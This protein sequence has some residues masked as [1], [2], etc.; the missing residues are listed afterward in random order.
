MNEDTIKRE[1]NQMPTERHRLSYF[2]FNGQAEQMKLH[3]DQIQS[4][5]KDFTPKPKFFWLS[6]SIFLS[7]YLTKS[8]RF[9]QKQ[10]NGESEYQSI[11][12]PSP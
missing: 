4:V 2:L 5:E 9:I 7:V 6:F 3:M 8:P 1:E 11:N 12:T 10:P